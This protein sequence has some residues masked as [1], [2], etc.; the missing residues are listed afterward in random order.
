MHLGMDISDALPD[1]IRQNK[2]KSNLFGNGFEN[3][4]LVSTLIVSKRGTSPLA[5]SLAAVRTSPTEPF[6]HF[7]GNAKV[8]TDHRC[9]SSHGCRRPSGP[10]SSAFPTGDGARTR[11]RGLE[12]HGSPACPRDVH[13][14]VAE[15]HPLLAMIGE[16]FRKLVD[17][18]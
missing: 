13:T 11:Q 8:R 2:K 7:R 3:G 5:G 17:K 12:S 10:R 14:E 16:E 1:A 15:T 6:G 4:G 9:G 18:T